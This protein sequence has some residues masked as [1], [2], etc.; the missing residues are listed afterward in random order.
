MQPQTTISLVVL[1]LLAVLIIYYFVNKRN[2]EDDLVKP[3]PEDEE[4]PLEET[5]EAS[6]LVIIPYIIGLH[7]E[8]AV[9]A[10]EENK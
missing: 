6:E 9:K 10:L 3:M 2:N 8:D 5:G 1:T 7:Q 4:D